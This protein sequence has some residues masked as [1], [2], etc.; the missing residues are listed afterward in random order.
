MFHLVPIC[1]SMTIRK[2][3]KSQQNCCFC[4]V[5]PEKH[6]LMDSEINYMLKNSFAE[7][8]AS[9]WVCLICFL[10]NLIATNKFAP[11]LGKLTVSL[12]PTHTLFHA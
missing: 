7:L 10:Q 1:W 3:M 2:G 5:S 9:S 12:Y 8:S 11:I 6:K 4:Q